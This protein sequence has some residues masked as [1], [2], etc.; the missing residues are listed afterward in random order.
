V[1]DDTAMSMASDTVFDFIILSRGVKEECKKDM[2]S[3]VYLYQR[4]AKK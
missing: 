3:T 2:I 1:V 4:K